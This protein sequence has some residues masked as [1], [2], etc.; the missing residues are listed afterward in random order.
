MPNKKDAE[1]AFIKTL[2]ANGQ[3]FYG[4]GK[5]PR[6]FTHRGTIDPKTGKKTIKRER[7]S[8]V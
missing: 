1:A 5:L 7:L 3:I 4:K 8:A 2:E 6:G